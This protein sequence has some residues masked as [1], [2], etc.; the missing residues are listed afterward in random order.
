MVPGQR[1]VWKNALLPAGVGLVLA[2][3]V[4]VGHLWLL[5]D[6]FSIFVR[7]APPFAQAEKLPPGLHPLDP[8]QVYD[9]QFFYRLAIDPSASRDVG[10]SFDHPS[11]RQ[12]RILYPL[13]ARGLSA[14]QDAWVPFVLV[15]I[16]VVGLA[17][18]GALGAR[19]AV[20][21]GAPAW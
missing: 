16:N 19:F 9:G 12:Q 4:V 1:P 14:G 5:G 8:A 6:D 21:C 15:A 20:E 7:T 13:I 11:Y 18:L 2:L 3:V 10:I 17:V